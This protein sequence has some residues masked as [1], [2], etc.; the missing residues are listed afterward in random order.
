MHG[1]LIVYI[2]IV[3]VPCMLTPRVRQIGIYTRL[4]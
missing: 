3:I 1:V 4:H 2:V